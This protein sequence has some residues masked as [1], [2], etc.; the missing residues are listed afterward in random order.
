MDAEGY[1][2]QPELNRIEKWDAFDAFN[3]IE[4]ITSRWA[5]Q[6]W[7]IKKYWDKDEYNGKSEVLKLEL[8]TAGWSGNEDLITA[9]LSNTMFRSMWYNQWRRGGHY[10][11]IIDPFNIGFMPVNDFAKKH[12]VSKQAIHKSKD[13]YEWLDCGNRKL[14]VRFKDYAERLNRK[15]NPERSVAT[16]SARSNADSNTK[17][18]E[19]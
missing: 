4:F 12:L 9:L 17:Q 7:G 3:L 1:P 11:F 8:H 10:Y 2:E 14:M 13:R 19:P 5:Y 18:I 16:E 6:D 15:Q